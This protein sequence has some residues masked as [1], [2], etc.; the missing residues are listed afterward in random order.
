MSLATLF[1]FLRTSPSIDD[2][3]SSFAPRVC[4]RG[5]RHFPIKFEKLTRES[6]ERGYFILSVTA[7]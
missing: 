6:H 4:A 2:R 7:F 5:A 3:A 1:F